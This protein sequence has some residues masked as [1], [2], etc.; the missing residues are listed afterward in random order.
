MTWELRA[1]DC[2]DAV[3]G[4]A[5][6]ADASVD[7]VIT[8]PPYDEQTHSRGGNVRRY[9]GGPQ[10]AALTFAA[11]EPGLIPA[12]AGHLCRVTRRWIVVFVAVRRIESWAAALEDAGAKVPRVMAWV[13]PDAS[14]QFSGDRPG[15]GFESVILAHR[16]GRTRWNGG[17]KKGVYV[18]PRMDF[19]SGHHHPTQKP[20]A[21]MSALVADFTDRGELICDPFA[22]SGTTGVAAIRGGRRFI[23]WE[24]DAQY[25]ETAR[26]R[27]ADAREQLS[28]FAAAS[29]S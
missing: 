4:L 14:P 1:S 22:G 6:L 3:S 17:G 28:L 21:L 7:H 25:A 12:I 16:V 11:L 8:D 18:V 27:L 23:G 2:L 15:H 9:D 20:L 10:I 19:M 29:D 5:S 13:K 24:R 26:R